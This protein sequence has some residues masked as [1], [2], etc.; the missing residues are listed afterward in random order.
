LQHILDTTDGTHSLQIDTVCTYNFDR[1][2]KPTRRIY[3]SLYYYCHL[4]HANLLG[5]WFLNIF[6]TILK[7]IFGITVKKLPNK[8]GVN[9]EFH[10]Y[11]TIYLKQIMYQVMKDIE[12]GFEG[13]NKFPKIL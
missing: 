2:R 12:I 13:E 11:G 7:C 8:Y 5:L 3:C 10:L 4:N 1:W 9:F 6:L